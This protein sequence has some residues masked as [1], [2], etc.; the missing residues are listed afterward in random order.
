[1]IA[2]HISLN[3]IIRVFSVLQYLMKKSETGCKFDLITII[4]VTGSSDAMRRARGQAH[5]EFGRIRARGAVNVS[6]AW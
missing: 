1:M 2:H 6:S 3:Q 4:A 5:S